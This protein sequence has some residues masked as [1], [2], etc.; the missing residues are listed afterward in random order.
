MLKLTSLLPIVISLTACEGAVA[1][2]DRDADMGSA[3]EATTSEPVPES[4][5][6]DADSSAVDTESAVTPEPSADLSVSGSVQVVH[7]SPDAPAVDFVV[8][9][10]RRVLRDIEYLDASRSAIVPAGTYPVDFPPS[11]GGGSVVSTEVEV[12]PGLGYTVLAFDA[13]ADIR[14]GVIVNDVGGLAPG[15]VRLQV[16]HTAVGVGA[17]DVW[18]LDSGTKILDDFNF[19]FYGALD[20]PPVPLNLGLDLDEDAIPDV[21][22]SVPVLGVDTLVNVFVVNDDDGVALY[23]VNL[24]GT[25]ARVDADAGADP[26]DAPPIIPGD[27]RYDRTDVTITSD[28]CDLMSGSR[29]GVSDEE[30]YGWWLPKQARLATGEGFFDWR[31]NDNVRI[32]SWPL[33]TE[34]PIRCDYDGTSFACDD[35]SARQAGGDSGLVFSFYE[36]E[37]EGEIFS[38][39]QLET[40]VSVTFLELDTFSAAYLGAFGIDYTECEVGATMEWTLI[41]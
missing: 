40:R 2:L 38:A 26:G 17:V 6:G 35:Q 9:E 10:S 39:D 5:P 4:G 20:L 24:D 23:A 22:F 3:I 11:A 14:S 27:G 25:T 19:A 30:V 37:V 7:L 21:T 28:N 18:E 34:A 36:I 16:V 41:D 33:E 32:E 13:L 8:N 12:S 31:E 1:T 29:Y 15:F